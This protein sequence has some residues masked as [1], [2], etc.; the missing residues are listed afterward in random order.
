MI[1]I[2]LRQMSARKKQ[3]ILTLIGIIL[4]AAAYI[5]ISGVMLG[6][7]EYLI[8]QLVNNDAHI[9]I[10]SKVKIITP[11]EVNPILFSFKEVPNWI[12]PPSGRRDSAQIE[13]QAGWLSKVSNDSNVEA[14]SPQLQVKVFF[15]KGKIVESG[16][17]VGIKPEQHSKVVRIKDN[18]IAGDFNEL[19]QSGNKMVIGN[20]LRLLLGANVSDTI[21]LNTMFAEPMAFKIVG[22]FQMGNKAIDDS[23]AYINLSDAQSFNK[24]PSKLSDILV[25]LKNV[26]LAT[27]IANDWAK[28]ESVRVQSWEEVNASFI[29]LFKLQD[30]I[31]YA[32]VTTILLVAS[33]GIYNILNI[34]ISQKRIEIAILRSIGFE[35][36]DILQIFLYQGIIL[37]ITGGILGMLIGAAVSSRLENVSFSNPLMQTKSGMMM[38]SY[39][40]KIYIQAFL[41]AFISTLIA[42][43]IP[44]R[45]ASKLSPIEIIRGE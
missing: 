28:D 8:D 44:A 5:I 23:T 35:A 21:F 36:K 10:S 40:P 43:I 27:P 1:F 42:S 34:V 25:R 37:G 11:V 20:G 30:T 12:A 39:D 15:K 22:I 9:R 41:L 4:G 18:I 45:G 3:T 33:F 26:N 24:T 19:S 14:I 31:R 29:S 7:R 16:R 13:N 2:A 6:L 32:L 38:I 17:I